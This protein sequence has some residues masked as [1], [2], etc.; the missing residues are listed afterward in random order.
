MISLPGKPGGIYSLRM[1]GDFHVDADITR[2]ETLP[3]RAF[4]DPAFLDR[5]LETVFA[6]NW[7]LVPPRTESELRNDPRD[8]AEM[9]QRRGSRAPVSFLDR[10]LFLQRDWDGGLHCF[11]NVCTHAWHV[12][13]EG[14]ERDR[15]IT[16][17][18]HGRKFDCQGKFV[19]HA[20]FEPRPC[21]D[22]VEFPLEEPGG[23]LWTC[24][25]KPVTP[26]SKVLEGISFPEMKRRP[27]SNE[28]RVV[29]GNWKQHAWNFLDRFH[30]GFIHRAP[31]G[32]A[33]AV[34]MKTYRTEIFDHSVLQEVW[35]DN[36]AAGF[37]GGENGK[38]LFARWWFLF[39]N[40]A[41]NFYPWG[42]SVNVYMPVPGRPGETLFHWYH[43]V[44]DEARYG[45]RDELWLNDAVDTED[46]EAMMQ[47]RRGAES[48]Y[49]VR[50]RFS[51]AEE[52]AAHWFHRR[53]SL[54]VS[55]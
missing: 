4:T 7:L 54:E 10:P 29:A 13:V 36:P 51:P 21:D 45:K 44:A 50:G 38:Y 9:V 30:I 31:G 42:L 55:S 19:R 17:P 15:Q 26:L 52:R 35:T 11:P 8:L 25:G 6:R 28:V 14:P 33:D 32:L 5:E 20:G 39:P 2:A 27:Q 3:A 40:L 34:D 47:V 1:A 16:C 46:Q 22:L 12:L 43:Y 23:F 41:L 37:G 18:Q 53:V 24:L 48:G 49:A